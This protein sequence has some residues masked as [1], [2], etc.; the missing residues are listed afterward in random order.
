MR[1]VSLAVRTVW[2]VWIIP[3]AIT[4][5]K[6]VLTHIFIMENACKTVQKPL[7]K[8]TTNVLTV[9]SAVYHV[10]TMTLALHATLQLICTLRTQ[11]LFVLKNVLR[12]TSGI[13]I[14]DNARNVL[15][16][17]FRVSMQLNAVNVSV[18]PMKS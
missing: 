14:P 13:Q 15:P 5:M 1:L 4:A 18:L 16:T 8:I 3:N 9:G 2:N 7:T 11:G 6:G 12:P 17:A 10:I